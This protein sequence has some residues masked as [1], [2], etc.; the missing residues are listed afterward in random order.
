L[1]LDAIR[2]T[3]PGV[4]RGIVILFD[5]DEDS[6]VQFKAIIESIRNAKLKYPLPDKLLEIKRGDPTIAVG[7]LPW[8]N[9]QGHLDELIFESLQESH[10]D[11]LTPIE[12]YCKGTAHRTGTWKFGKKSKMRLRCMIAASHEADPSIG[13]RYFLESSKCPVD[14]NHACFDPL[15]KFLEEFRRVV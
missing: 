5:S 14:F 11:L 13:L 1:A 9:R 3:K 4:A 15:V 2:E 8:I 6:D 10:K 7:L 12:E